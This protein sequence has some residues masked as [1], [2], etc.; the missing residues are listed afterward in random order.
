MEK[1]YPTPYSIIL[2]NT[3]NGS[4]TIINCKVPLED[5]DVDLFQMK[6]INPKVMI[7]DG[8]E[9]KA[10]MRALELFPKAITILDAGSVREGT[11]ALAKKV[12]YFIASERFVLT[13]CGMDS[14]DSE[15]D[16]EN[17]INK[18][19]NLCKGQ[20]VVTLG[21]RGLMYE[22][23]GKVK[24]LNSYKVK[25]VDTTGAGD[26]FYGAFAYGLIKGYSLLD[27]LKFS[28]MVSALSVEKL[29]ERQSI[30]ELDIV[31]ERLNKV[32]L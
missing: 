12:D 24:K 16:Y 7:F 17:C 30:P 31:L 4:R 27:N 8:Y 21:E 10:S 18:M 22:N 14:I 6:K 25:V 28:S 13:Y 1:G 11:I 19:K 15:E 9:L 26:I 29:G 3:N 23:G 5:L 32:E 2:V 20:I